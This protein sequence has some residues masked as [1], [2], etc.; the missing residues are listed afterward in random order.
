MAA[1]SAVPALSAETQSKWTAFKIWQ[2]KRRI[3]ISLVAFTALVSFNIV[4]LKTRP[5]YLLDCTSFGTIGGLG[6]IASGLALRSWAAGII[7]KSR[8]LIQA[9]PYA[10]IRN[11]LYVGSFLMMFGFCVLLRDLLSLLFICGPMVSLYWT[12]VLQ[13][14]K[15]LAA[16]FPKDWPSYERTVS[17]F[18]PRRIPINISGN[19]SLVQW[20]LN[21]EYQA[22]AGSLLGV[23]ATLYW[24]WLSHR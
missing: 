10:I 17:R 18:M 19:W 21:R 9:G 11:P 5:Q 1:R 15:N 2:T 13:E 22:L 6:L 4:V 20:H 23:L 3:T 7:R 14:E 8:A 24:S 16:L 12:K